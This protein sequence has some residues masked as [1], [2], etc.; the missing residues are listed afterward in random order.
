MRVYK[1]PEMPILESNRKSIFLAGTIDM[2]NSENW[3]KEVS[4]FFEDEDDIDIYNPRREDWDNSWQQDFTN[5]QFFQQVNWELNQLDKATAIIMNF[6]SDSK[7]PIT[8]LELGV[9]IHS[10]KL[11]VCCPD[12]FYRAGNVHILC[13]RFNVPCFKNI[14]QTCKNVHNDLYILG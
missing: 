4:N 12:D 2:G 1:P 7:S 8:L 14:H 3:Q 11:Y 5:P 9:Y 10:N 6:L 13:D